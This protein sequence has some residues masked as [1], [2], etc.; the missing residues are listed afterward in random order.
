MSPI[1]TVMTGLLAASLATPALASG[2]SC[3]T[4]EERSALDIRALQSQLMVVALTCQQEE[5]YNRFVTQHRGVL[6]NVYG[7]VQRHFRRVYG[8]AGQRRLDEYITNTANGHSQ[9]GIS[10]GSLFCQN[11]AGL[12]PAALATN[13]RDQLAHLSQE[14]QIQQVYSPTACGTPATRSASSTPSTRPAQQ[15]RPQRAA[16]QQQP[17]RAAN[18]SAPRS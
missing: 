16:S 17:A 6:G 14:R 10:Q 3:A 7:Q 5:Q 2:Q 12:F 15:A 8:G 11:Q 13:N 1:R 18:A 9:V 4:P